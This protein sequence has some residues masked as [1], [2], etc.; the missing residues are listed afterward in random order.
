MITQGLSTNASSTHLLFSSCWGTEV[1][2]SP[3]PLRVLPRCMEGAARPSLMPCMALTHS[4]PG[5][6]L[7]AGGPGAELGSTP[8]CDRGG[9]HPGPG[10][11]VVSPRPPSGKT[12]FT[13]G[14][15]ILTSSGEDV[16][17]RLHRLPC[18]Q[19]VLPRAPPVE[20]HGRGGL[21]LGTQLPRDSHGPD[22]LTAA[23]C[24]RQ[25]SDGCLPRVQP[26]TPKALVTPCML[27]PAPRAD[28]PC[29]LSTT[30]MQPP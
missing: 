12:G 1:S 11:R 5:W 28:T 7:T 3:V 18:P 26:C 8:C 24:W 20:P 17:S 16:G 30:R 29:M 6:G 4:G 21:S 14:P 13:P 23:P 9:R 10:T 22:T 19:L 15:S 25:N 27:S 2:F